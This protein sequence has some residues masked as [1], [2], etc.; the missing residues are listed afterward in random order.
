MNHT[1]KLGGATLALLTLIAITG[2]EDPAKGKAKANTTEALPTTQSAVQPASAGT[3]ITETSAAKSYAFDQS[4]SKITFVGSKVTGKHDGGFK[5]FSGTI[6]APDGAPEKGSVTVDI[7]ATSIWADNEKL[8]GHLQSKD[9]FDV[10]T[11]PKATF[12]S[13]KIDKGGEKGATHTVTGNL[14]LHGVTKGVSFPATVKIE[15]DTVSVDSEFAIN[16]KDFGLLYP[17]KQDDLIRDDVV[18]KLAIK[19]KKS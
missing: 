8:T 3:G 2:C 12:V 15:G 13:T 19:A 7:D 11:F 6:K 5:T 16:R 18:I 17:G 14:T 9:F 4:T 10:S 1:T